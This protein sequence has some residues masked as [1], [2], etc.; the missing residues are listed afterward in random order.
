[1]PILSPKRSSPHRTRAADSA[2]RLGPR[3][4]AEYATR[5]PKRVLTAWAVAVLV[6]LGL[7]ATLL[8]SGLTSDAN[9]TNNPESYAAQD[10]IDARLPQQDP[11][12]EVIVVRSER[13]VVSDRAFRARVGALVD[14]ARRG[15]G[16]ERISSYLDPGGELLV[17]ADRHAT[18][19]PVVLVKGEGEA[20]ADL[21][22]VVERADGSGG[23]AADITG[24]Q[25]LDRDFE[26]L[27]PRWLAWIPDLQ[28]EGPE[29]EPPPD[30][31]RHDD[32][33]KLPPAAIPAAP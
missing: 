22:S 30:R 24:S 25:T 4:L 21:I 26:R 2:S 19:V 28:V 27:L 3:A 10:L 32:E 6:S 8:G 11:V 14:E 15:G 12:D 20:I 29:A 7:V 16:V 13:L 1:M 18:L 9:L 23:F 31:T 33:P 17:S 5:R